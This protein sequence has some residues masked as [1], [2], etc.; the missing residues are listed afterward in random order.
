MVFGSAVLCPL[1]DRSDL[2]SITTG[3]NGSADGD[4][5]R[6]VGVCGC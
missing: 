1:A 5:E 4:W 6:E 3:E 2:E